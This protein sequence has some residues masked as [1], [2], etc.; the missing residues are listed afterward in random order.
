M[1][2]Q[3]SKPAPVSTNSKLWPLKN[4]FFA[5]VRSPNPQTMRLN[6]HTPFPPPIHLHHI[7]S[8]A[9]LDII[10]YNRICLC[11]LAGLDPRGKKRFYSKNRTYIHNLNIQSQY[12]DKRPDYPFAITL[13]VGKQNSYLPQPVTPTA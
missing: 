4:R 7:Y 8:N 1:G 10:P 11:P 2:L 13:M 5:I 6:C 3:G 9:F 12:P